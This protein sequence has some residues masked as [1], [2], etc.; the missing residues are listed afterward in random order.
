MEPT[1]VTARPVREVAAVVQNRTMATTRKGSAALAT[2]A[3]TVALGLAGCGDDSD[4]DADRDASSNVDD[5]DDTDA[6]T[7]TPPD[8][9]QIRR[10]LETS[11][12]P[13]APSDPSATPLP[14]DCTAVAQGQLEAAVE[15][16]ACD[17]DGVV[18]RLGPAEIEG[19]VEDAEAESDDNGG[20]LVMIEFDRDAS[21]TFADLTTELAGTEQYLPVLDGPPT[22]F[23]A[24][25]RVGITCHVAS[26]LGTWGLRSPIYFPSRDDV[27][28]ANEVQ[29]HLRDDHAAAHPAVS[30]AAPHGCG[31]EQRRQL[32]LV[33]LRTRGQRRLLGV[34]ADDRVPG[35]RGHPRTQ[36]LHHLAR[37]VGRTPR[38]SHASPASTR[39]RLRAPGRRAS[40]AGSPLGTWRTRHQTARGS[41]SPAAPPPGCRM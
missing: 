5:R 17:E 20:W 21:A 33:H 8:P 29:R 3:V 28:Y 14:S 4:R 37:A 39:S 41:R 32:P 36:T 12:G 35:L 27:T 22:A 34:V 40:S 38:C 10:V 30:A 25:E 19:G 6:P 11:E 1:Y 24:G 2:L 31:T 13:S 15:A 18:Y 26:V 9:M 23:R 16:V 7:D